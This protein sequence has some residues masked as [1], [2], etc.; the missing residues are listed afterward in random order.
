MLGRKDCPQGHHHEFDI[1]NGHAGPFCLFLHILHH[2][3]ELGDAIHLHIILHHISAEE[4]HVDGMQPPAV[5]VE[6]GHDVAGRDLRVE[7]LG[8]LEIIVPD[9]VDNVTKE[10]CDASFGR[11]VTGVVVKV[12]F[13]GGLCSN[14]DDCCGIVGNVFVVEG[15]A[16]GPDKLGIAMVGFVLGG[17]REYGREGMDSFHLIIRDDH[18]QWEKGLPDCEQVVV[19]WLPFEGGGGVICLFEEEGDWVG[20]HFC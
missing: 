7:R 11:L 15:E 5:G 2:D 14:T 13:M 20:V 12:G 1:G 3:N 18:E 9:L 19:G 6:E 8:V 4:D 10:F 16:D 17:I